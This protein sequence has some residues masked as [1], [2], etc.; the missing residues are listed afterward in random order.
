[1]EEVLKVLHLSTVKQ[2]VDA[3]RAADALGVGVRL[4]NEYVVED[5][6]EGVLTEQWTMTVLVDLKDP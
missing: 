4:E 5:A 1:M 2:A 6:D 3:L